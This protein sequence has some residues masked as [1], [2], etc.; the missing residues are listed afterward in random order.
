M[1]V[2]WDKEHR[3]M[4]IAIYQLHC[5]FLWYG[6]CHKSHEIIF[7]ISWTLICVYVTGPCLFFNYLRLL[8]WLNFV[9][10]GLA[11]IAFN[12]GNLDSKTLREALSLAPTYFVMKFVQ[13]KFFCFANCFLVCHCRLV[14]FIN[15]MFGLACYKIQS[16]SFSFKHF[17]LSG[18]RCAW[19]FNDVWCLCYD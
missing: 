12:D 14:Q 16:F 9:I 13:S 1:L 4:L 19:H 17:P 8:C 6:L 7:T 10:Q 5:F 3:V 11:I 18:G 2:L 15:L